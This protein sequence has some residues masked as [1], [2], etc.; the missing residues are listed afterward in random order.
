M[1]EEVPRLGPNF[2]ASLDTLN[3]AFRF[4]EKS[5][6]QQEAQFESVTQSHRRKLFLRGQIKALQ[7]KVRA[8]LSKTPVFCADSPLVP[9][10]WQFSGIAG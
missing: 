6:G 7:P 2:Q 8:S 1:T 10:F 4:S 5:L 9:E 3:R